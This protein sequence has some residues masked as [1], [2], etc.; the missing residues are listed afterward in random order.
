VLPHLGHGE[1]EREI[2]PGWIQYDCGPKDCSKGHE[3][4]RIYRW[5]TGEDPRS[6]H[7]FDHHLTTAAEGVVHRS[8][9][10]AGRHGCGRATSMAYVLLP[11]NNISGLNWDLEVHSHKVTTIP[12][13][14]TRSRSPT[15]QQKGRHYVTATFR[16]VP[17][18]TVSFSTCYGTKSSQ[19]VP[20]ASTS[21]A[22][23]HGRRGPSGEVLVMATVDPE[24]CS[25]VAAEKA[26][27]SGKE[28]R[29]SSL[30]G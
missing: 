15:S 27:L 11:I 5:S 19:S 1:I 13:K 18:R 10:A 26:F 12:A 30:V 21:A 24:P 28:R 9:S 17:R 16:C 6:Q 20:N 14:L 8:C 7:P 23:L 25:E 29:V 4:T 3:L 22:S 2:V